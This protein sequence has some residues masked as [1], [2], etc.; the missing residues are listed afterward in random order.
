MILDL[1]PG[2]YRILGYMLVTSIGVLSLMPGSSLPQFS[3]DRAFGI[4]KIFHFFFYGLAG[5]CFFK[6]AEGNAVNKITLCLFSFGLLLECLQKI[7]PGGRFF[8][9]ADLVANLLGIL[10]AI[11]MLKLSI[12]KISRD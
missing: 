8:D 10:A 12:K 3:W 1:Q 11:G 4:D 2:H 5:F 6:S 7:L 9:V